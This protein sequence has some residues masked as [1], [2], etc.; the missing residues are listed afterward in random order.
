MPLSWFIVARFIHY[1]YTFYLHLFNSKKKKK[2]NLFRSFRSA[3]KYFESA[4]S[5]LDLSGDD[6]QTV[7]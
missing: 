4:H 5:E 3:I 7:F 1:M 2:K 6:K